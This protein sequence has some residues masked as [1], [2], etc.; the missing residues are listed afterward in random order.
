MKGFK[1]YHMDCRANSEGCCTIL[2]L[3]AKGHKLDINHCGFYK[4]NKQWKAEVEKCEAHL[5]EIGKYDLVI[6]YRKML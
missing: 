3:T 1:C 2:S 6:Y 4:T 5:K